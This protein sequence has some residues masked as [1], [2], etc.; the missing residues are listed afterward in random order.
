MKQIKYKKYPKDYTIFIRTAYND[1]IGILVGGYTKPNVW[2][3]RTTN[4]HFGEPG[5]TPDDFMRKNPIYKYSYF[6]N[7]TEHFITP[8]PSTSSVII[9]TNQENTIIGMCKYTAG[10]WYMYTTIYD[11]TNYKTFDDILLNYPAYKFYEL[12]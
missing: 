6:E 8:A 12:P 2:V 4:T 1:M 10:F 5:L 7:L 3:G 9:I 11:T